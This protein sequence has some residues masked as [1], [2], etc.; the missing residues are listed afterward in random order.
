MPLIGA[1]LSSA[2]ALSLWSCPQ[3]PSVLGSPSHEEVEEARS[4]P[5]G[6]SKG[7]H[8]RPLFTTLQGGALE[9]D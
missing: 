7:V 6:C 4:G 5:E 3:G 8:S 1:E 9:Q 2:A